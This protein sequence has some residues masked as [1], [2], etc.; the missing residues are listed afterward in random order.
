[1]RVN[2]ASQN[3]LDV[4]AMVVFCRNVVDGELA[5]MRW[6]RP[7]ATLRFRSRTQ[8]TV[9]QWPVARRTLDRR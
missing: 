2:E 4:V 5:K 1:M 6:E 3:L 9:K 7:A 8:W